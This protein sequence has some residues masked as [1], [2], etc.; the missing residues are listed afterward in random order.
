MN[1]YE[2]AILAQ[3]KLPKDSKWTLIKYLSYTKFLASCAC[4]KEQEV[5]RSN[6]LDGKSKK[7]KSCSAKESGFSKTHGF[8]KEKLYLVWNGIKARCYN[9]NQSNYIR[10][11]GKGIVMCDEWLNDYIS[12]RNFAINNGYKI[13]LEIDRIESNGNYEPSNC[14]FITKQENGYRANIGLKHSSERRL[15]RLL[16]IFN[17]EIEDLD[18]II[19]CATSGLFLRKELAKETGIDVNALGNILKRYGFTP[20][21]RSPKKSSNP[22]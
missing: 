16:K 14:R 9:K 12:F 20:A 2:K 5:W 1:A 21:W 4:G 13:G 8:S 3:K 15:N 22:F 17:L 11:G 19:E 7:C 10:Y 18:D 6:V